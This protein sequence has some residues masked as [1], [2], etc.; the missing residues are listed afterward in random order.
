LLYNKKSFIDT[1]EDI[2]ASVVGGVEHLEH[3][4]IPIAS[5]DDVNE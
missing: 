4:D 1:P 3:M 2:R 5:D